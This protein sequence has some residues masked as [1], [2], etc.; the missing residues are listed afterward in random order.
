MNFNTILTNG[1]IL[2]THI[3]LCRPFHEL[4]CQY[5]EERNKLGM[6]IIENSIKTFESK[7]AQQVIDHMMNN[8]DTSNVNYHFIMKVISLTIP[9]VIRK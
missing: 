1:F 2:L 7:F 6:K 4:D 9:H 5:C 3:R 8:P